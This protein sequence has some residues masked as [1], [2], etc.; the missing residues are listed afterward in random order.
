MMDELEQRILEKVKKKHTISG[1][2]NG[3]AIALLGYDLDVACEDL[4]K[5]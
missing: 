5:F 2:N 3:Y 4:K 1:G